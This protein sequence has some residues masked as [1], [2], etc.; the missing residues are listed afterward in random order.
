MRSKTRTMEQFTAWMDSALVWLQETDPVYLMAGGGGLIVLFGLIAATRMNSRKKEAAQAPSLR[1]SS[2]QI[3]PLGRDAFMKL[4][5]TGEQATLSAIAVKGRRD[6]IIKNEVAGQVIPK[7]GTYSILFEVS[8]QHR[9][10]PNFTIEL[11]YI[12]QRHK[13]YL[14]VFGLDPVS[15]LSLKQVKRG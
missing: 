5:N 9:L 4:E 12:D 1:I 3:A 13:A 15:S 6:V 7:A 11:T 10:A 14:Q 2:F 8:G